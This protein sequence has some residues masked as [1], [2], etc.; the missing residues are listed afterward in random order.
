MPVLPIE[1]GGCF[2]CGDGEKIIPENV[3]ILISDG[4]DKK[5]SWYFILLQ[6]RQ[7]IFV[8]VSKAIVETETDIEPVVAKFLRVEIIQGNGI[9]KLFEKAQL[10][11]KYLPGNKKSIKFQ[12]ISRANAVINKDAG[13]SCIAVKTV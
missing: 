4:C 12:G 7:H 9:K 8:V 13:A 1:C 6:Q 3:H 10:L 5:N 11:L 2:C